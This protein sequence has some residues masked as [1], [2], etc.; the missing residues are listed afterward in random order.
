M[1]CSNDCGASRRMDLIVL[2]KYESIN[3]NTDFTRMY[4]R[5]KSVTDPALVIYAMKNRAG[6]CRIG[7]T[8][9][10]KTGNA[11]ERN[12]SRRIIR[13]AF[14][15]ALKQG[16]IDGWDIVIVARS[17]TKYM[18]STQLVPIMLRMLASLGVIRRQCD[19]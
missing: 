8:V 9:S 6:F 2:Q 19:F 17:K 15:A 4:H 5:A 14:A 10:K 11:V 3:Q 7:I 12:R 18:K 1:I 13:A 16:E